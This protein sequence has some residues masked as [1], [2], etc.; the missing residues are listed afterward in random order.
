MSTVE[1]DKWNE[2]YREGAYEERT[3]PTALLAEWLPR[4]PRGTALDVAC[5]AGRNAIY[6]AAHGYR[7]TAVDNRGVGRSSLPDGESNLVVVDALM[8]FIRVGNLTGFP[9]LS[10]PAGFDQQGLPVGVHLMGRPWEEHLLLRLGRVI[11]RHQ[12]VLV[13]PDHARALLA[14]H[15]GDAHRPVRGT[16]GDRARARRRLQPARLPARRPRD[17]GSAG[18]HEPAPRS[19][20]A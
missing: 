18:R 17:A 6:L 12:E 1:R 7:V 9:A 16:G 19:A 13:P 3:H 5:G 8:R 10:V 4:L 11:E 15:L 14:V 20:P 2:R